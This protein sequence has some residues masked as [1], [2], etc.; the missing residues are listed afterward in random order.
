MV[1]SESGDDGFWK[2]IV[3]EVYKDVDRFFKMIGE[4]YVVFLDFIKVRIRKLLFFDY[5]V[6]I[7]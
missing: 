7:I 2:E 6:F 4:V 1:R 3:E 5:I